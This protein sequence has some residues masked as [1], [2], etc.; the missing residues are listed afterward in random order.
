MGYA[1]PAPSNIV[2]ILPIIGCSLLIIGSVLFFIWYNNKKKIIQTPGNEGES[3]RRIRIGE[4]PNQR[5]IMRETLTD[6]KVYNHG[7]ETNQGQI[8]RETTTDNKVYSH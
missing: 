3:N 6:D 8:M 2:I 7:R 5:L 4:M 1:S